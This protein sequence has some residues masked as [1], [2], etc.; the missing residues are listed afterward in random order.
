MPQ[1]VTPEVAAQ[2]A[3]H[4]TDLQRLL[5][6]RGLHARLLTSDD[7]LPRLRVINPEATALSE[8]ISAAPEEGRW[9]FWWSWCEPIAEV[10][11]LAPAA[12]RITH[13]LATAPPNAA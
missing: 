5:H 12:H 6:D 9:L 7:R 1:P 2:A 8:I 4:L 10:T 3:G 13:V 11:H